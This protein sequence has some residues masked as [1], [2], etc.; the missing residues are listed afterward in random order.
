MPR[1]LLKFLVM[2]DQDA[3]STEAEIQQIIRTAGTRLDLGEE[4]QETWDKTVGNVG[5]EET[6]KESYNTVKEFFKKKEEKYFKYMDEFIKF[7]TEKVCIVN[8][9]ISS[10]IDEHQI[11]E[12]LNA[13]GTALDSIELAKNYF[14][15]RLK[16]TPEDMKKVNKDWIDTLNCKENNP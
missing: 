3:P 15:S 5:I 11:F 8:I 1:K 14:M 7:L 12:T 6:F 10:D 2:K 9:N 4:R 13:T 16:G